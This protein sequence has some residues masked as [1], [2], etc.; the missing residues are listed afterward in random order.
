MK[1]DHQLHLAA[2][3]AAGSARPAAP[4][5]CEGSGEGDTGEALATFPPALPTLTRWTHVFRKVDQ[6]LP[7]LEGLLGALMIL[8]LSQPRFILKVTTKTVP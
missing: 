8:M 1:P 4:G 5:S 6:A 3:A 2:A 7:D